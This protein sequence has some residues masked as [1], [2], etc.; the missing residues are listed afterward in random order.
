MLRKFILL[1]ALLASASVAAVETTKLSAFQHFEE[2]KSIILKDI[3]DNTVYNEISYSDM[4]MVKQTLDLMSSTLEDVIDVN[5][6]T[7]NQKADL[8]N[9][10]SLVNTILTMAE[11]DS[12]MVCRRRSTLGTNFKTTTCETV[13]DRRERQEADRLAIN[14]F[15]R[16]TPLQ[17]N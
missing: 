7:E 14:R 5:N 16:G 6:L 11:N 12:R 17:S 10:Q 4:K 9:H 8:F 15:L 2:Q 1:S 3:S 13:R